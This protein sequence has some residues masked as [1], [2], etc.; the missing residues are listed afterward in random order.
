ME[1]FQIEHFKHAKLIEVGTSVSADG[2]SRAEN[3]LK[4][5]RH[6]LVKVNENNC[7]ALEF[8]VNPN[9]ANARPG[10][11]FVLNRESLSSEQIA[12]LTQLSER[13]VA[14]QK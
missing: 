6:A 1:Q 10:Y 4:N 13:P 5:A 3:I 14:V 8:N 12:Y 11:V 9:A 7:F 2:F